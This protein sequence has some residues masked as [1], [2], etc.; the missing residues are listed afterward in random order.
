LG[1]DFLLCLSAAGVWL[2]A[3][4]GA[5]LAA[6]DAVCAGDREALGSLYLKYA[7]IGHAVAFR[8]L[9]SD[10]EAE[11]ILHDVFLEIWRHAS[12]YD[13]QRSSVRTWILLLV[14]SR[15]LDRYRSAAFRA[16][17]STSGLM[18]PTSGD[19]LEVNACMHDTPKLF[20]LIGCLPEPQR[21]VLELGYFEGL[22]AT[23]IA[24]RLGIPVG[25]VKSRMAAA[26]G[27]LR[28]AVDAAPGAVPS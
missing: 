21:V 1:F 18:H 6:M 28:Q 22:S 27:K 10:P 13:S 5:D 16:R 9:R 4:S 12:H 25:T 14:R 20:G 2:R 17:E 26:L 24:S 3:V 11:D 7:G 23:E 19:S 8:I 15:A